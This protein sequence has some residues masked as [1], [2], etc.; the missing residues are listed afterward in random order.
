VVVTGDTAAEQIDCQAAAPWTVLHKPVE[1]RSLVAAIEKA[2]AEAGSGKCDWAATLAGNAGVA[3]PR[4]GEPR[5]P[6]GGAP[7]PGLRRRAGR[8]GTGAA[9]A[10]TRGAIRVGASG[11]D[12][13][14]P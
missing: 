5:T 14:V 3:P 4:R 13:D 12:D 8:A 1:P 7:L 10:S 6:R 11:N 9:G 2:L